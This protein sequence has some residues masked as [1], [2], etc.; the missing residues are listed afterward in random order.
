MSAL[1]WPSNLGE[2]NNPSSIFFQFYERHTSTSSSIGDQIELYMPNSVSQPSTVDWSNKDVGLTGNA[3]AQRATSLREMDM[4]AQGAASQFRGAISQVSDMWGVVAERGAAGAAAATVGVAGGNVTADEMMGMSA[5]K[6]PNPYL[7]AIFKGVNFR[8]FAFEF[9]FAAL[10]EGDSDTIHDIIKTFRKN[11]LP[12]GSGFGANAEYPKG[13]LGYPNEVE[14]EYRFLGAGN[15][16]LHKFTR[17]V[18]VGVD[19]DYTDA[20][21]WYIHDNGFPTNIKLMLK[22][23]EI[24][25]VLR[26]DVEDG[27]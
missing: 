15:K 13:F 6:I 8:N 22:F 14:I 5:G 1:V 24:N 11:S 2:Y 12:P 17:A 26:D 3:M 7:T 21:G 27:Y 25:I 19:V 9:N 18:C 10:E 16:Y 20:G 23:S 4:S